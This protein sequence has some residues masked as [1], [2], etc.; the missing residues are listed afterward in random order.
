MQSI[1]KSEIYTTITQV[2]RLLN[3]LKMQAQE[4]ERLTRAERPR[5]DSRVFRVVSKCGTK[6]ITFA[7]R[8]RT[9]EVDGFEFGFSDSGS[10]KQFNK[11]LGV[12]I[13]YERLQNEPTRKAI[14][15]RNPDMGNIPNETLETQLFIGSLGCIF[16]ALTYENLSKKLR[17]MIV[18]P[19]AVQ[20]EVIMSSLQGVSV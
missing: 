12:Q 5:C 1:S 11:K 7:Y 3:A 16:G 17:P 20:T 15:F 10:E 8:R 19:G 2:E 14:R 13:A 6:A 4:A 18:K 9:A